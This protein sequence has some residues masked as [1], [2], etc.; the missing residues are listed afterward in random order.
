M[1]IRQRPVR[2]I[3][4]TALVAG[5]ALVAAAC[6]SS[7]SKS[8]S[9]SAAAGSSNTTTAPAASPATSFSVGMV[10]GLGDVV[11]DGL[12]HT[13]YILTA[14][15]KTNVPCSDA[16]GCTAIW[17]DLPL[18]DG[19]TAATAG[20]GLQASLLSTEKLADGETYPTYK[21]W[22]MYELSKD[23]ASGEAKGEGFHSFGGNW[24]ALSATGDPVLPPATTATTG[25]T[26]ATT[27]APSGGYGY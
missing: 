24:Y 9:V 5:L 2:A 15:G 17:P 18:P 13:V 20:T 10:A 3:G 11:V 23:T 19:T 22:L 12:G 4:T 1:L 21:G 16:S 6:G 26:T 25:A 14:D 27:A 7:S 8:S